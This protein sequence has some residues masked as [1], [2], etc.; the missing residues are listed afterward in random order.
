MR[1]G[2]E[3]MQFLANKSPYLRNSARYDQGY[4]DGL[5]GSCICAFSWHQGRWPWM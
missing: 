3:K 5:T 1:E 2:W 4:Y